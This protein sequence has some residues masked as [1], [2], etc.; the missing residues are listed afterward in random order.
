MLNFLSLS[1]V[2]HTTDSLTFQK[3]YVMLMGFQKNLKY[4]CAEHSIFEFYLMTDL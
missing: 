1:L 2:H 4:L 3:K